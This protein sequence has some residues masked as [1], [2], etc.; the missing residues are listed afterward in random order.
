[1]P[2]GVVWWEKLEYIETLT[3]PKYPLSAIITAEWAS[4]QSRGTML[5]A[6]FLMQSV[7]RLL[8]DGLS[9]GILVSTRL[10]WD[11]SQ[12]D[13]GSGSKM[14][15]DQVWRWTVGVGIIPAAIAII[16]R[17]TIP[18]TPRYYAGIM[19]DLRK[20]VRNTLRVYHNASVSEKAPKTSSITGR[21]HQNNGDDGRAP[22]Y[23]W[24]IGAWGYLTGP[25]KEWRTLT[26][27][28]LLWALLDVCF[29]GLSMDL[30]NDLSILFHDP[31]K[32]TQ[33]CP[34]DLPWNSDW[35][36][37]DPIYTVLSRNSRR[38][39]W[40][41]SMPAVVGGIVAIL[42]INS[43]RRKHI[44]AAT[45]VVIS[46]L[47]AIAGASLIVT[48]DLRKSHVITQVIYAILSFVFNLGE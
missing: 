24:Y 14:M 46:V 13:S 31:S 45:F 36:N 42:I 39:I 28:S 44:L 32:N 3:M 26:S 48:A 35:W 15:V 7:S 1:M 27:I 23:S 6:V 11:L 21:G 41:A 47:L 25:K 37:C 34:K 33:G 4:T 9:L 38:F 30:S 40:L 2:Q 18:E 16:M 43:F 8:V 19:K 12:N 5:A 17:L 22:W 20:A 29:Y 10:K